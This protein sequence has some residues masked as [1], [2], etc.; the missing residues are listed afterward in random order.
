VLHFDEFEW[1]IQDRKLVDFRGMATTHMG[2]HPMLKL[3]Q[4]LALVKRCDMLIYCR[5]DVMG[6]LKY[7]MIWKPEWKYS[8]DLL[9]RI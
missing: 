8:K 1:I 5:E 2:N 6:I 3:V 7:M 4:I 9:R